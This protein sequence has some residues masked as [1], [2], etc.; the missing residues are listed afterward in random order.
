MSKTKKELTAIIHCTSGEVTRVNDVVK[1]VYVPGVDMSVL[2]GQLSCV[3]ICKLLV[4][5]VYI[6][7]RLAL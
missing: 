1:V 5:A 3:P 7:D 2:E 6:K 4:N